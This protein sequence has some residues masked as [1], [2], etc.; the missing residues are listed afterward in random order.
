FSNHELELLLLITPQTAPTEDRSQ[1]KEKESRPK[2]DVSKPERKKRQL[3]RKRKTEPLFDN[4]IGR[5]Q[6]LNGIIV[7]ELEKNNS[8]KDLPSSTSLDTPHSH[9]TIIKNTS[10]RNS[11]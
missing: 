11:Q 10:T 5:S 6:L 4:T 1:A 8:R 2:A 9:S 3:S 7:P